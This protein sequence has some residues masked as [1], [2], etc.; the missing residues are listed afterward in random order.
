[1]INLYIFN[2]SSPAA[3]FGIGTYIRELTA[4]LKGSEIN[5]C[6]VHLRS[7][8]PDMEMKE[9]D[10]IQ[11]LHIPLYINRNVTL[12]WQRQNEL[13][14]QNVVYLLQ[15]QIKATNKLVFHLNYLN[16]KSLADSLKKVFDCK[17]VLV[18]HYLDSIMTLLGNISR[19]RRIISQPNEL[20][21]AEE[22]S[23]K[24]S[25]SQEKE[26]L[27][28]HAVDKVICLSN[29]AFDMLHQ[30]YQKEKEKMVV[31]YN[32]L[33]YNPS[34]MDKQTLRKKY[35]IPDIPIIL[36][37]GRLQ[38]AKGLIYLIKSFRK[39]RKK[40]PDCHLLIVGNGNYDTY[41]HEAKDICMNITFTGLLEKKELCEL[42]QIADVGV[43]PSFTENCSYVGIEMMM[44]GL[45]MLTTTAPGLSEMIEDGINGLQISI[46]EHSDRMEI[47][48]EVLADKMLYLL[49]HP[50]KTKRL[51]ENA[52]KRY[53]ELYS[54]DVF[55]KNMLDF[56]HSLY[57]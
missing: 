28:C 18:V 29:H 17:T 40:I 57:E 54:G 39:L 41:M 35:H 51:G 30:V 23:V 25:Y 31:I 27:Q 45:P 20:K 12:G 32:G 44:H 36:F 9:T 47:D 34:I 1:M 48:S 14:Y 21:N 38:E 37:V 19:L 5:V 7:E 11:H 4:A 26:I 55:R 13:Y 49:E 43:I 50:E 15:L 33:T 2:E 53:E 10:G 24:E 56:Y 42:Y 16:C 52:R 3:V 6:V 8:K 22:I 46:K